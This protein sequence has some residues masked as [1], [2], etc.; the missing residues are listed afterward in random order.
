MA[1]FGLHGI[2][3]RTPGR[4]KER[5]RQDIYEGLLDRGVAETTG[6]SD[7]GRP[8]FMRCACGVH[9]RWM[10][11]SGAHRRADT[12]QCKV[13]DE[14]TTRLCGPALRVAE[15]LDSLDM[16][17]A[18]EARPVGIATGPVDFYFPDLRLAIEVDGQQHYEGRMHGDSY[19]QV[20]HRDCQKMLKLWQAGVSVLRIPYFCLVYFYPQVLEAIRERQQH[21]HSRFVLLC[22][23]PIATTGCMERRGEQLPSWLEGM[24]ERRQ[25]LLAS[26]RPSP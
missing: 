19:L 17:Y 18:Y 1:T 20:Q 15:V 3:K 11:I 8:H 25:K 2:E 14:T 22:C 24:H 10:T 6:R 13:C 21:P 5:L 9:Y 16:M 26:P 23:P 7:S 12:L 4:H